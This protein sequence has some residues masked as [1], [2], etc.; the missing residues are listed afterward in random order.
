MTHDINLVTTMGSERDATA[1]L[2]ALDQS[3]HVNLRR[4]ALI[5]ECNAYTEVLGRWDTVFGCWR[6]LG[7]GALCAAVVSQDV[8]GKFGCPAASVDLAIGERPQSCDAAAAFES[9]NSEIPRAVRAC[10][11]RFRGAQWL[12]LETSWHEPCLL[13]TFLTAKGRRFA[14]A[15]LCL[16]DARRKVVASHRTLYARLAFCRKRELLSELLDREC[17][18]GLVNLVSMFEHRHE[19]IGLSRIT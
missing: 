12:A 2:R 19:Q 17:G 15:A 13:E 6:S 8:I 9:Y 4:E 18:V 16:T 11:A 14:M 3:I 5:I 10:V 7:S 1:G